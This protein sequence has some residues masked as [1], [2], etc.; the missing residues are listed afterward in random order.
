MIQKISVCYT[1]FKKIFKIE[2]FAFMIQIKFQILK[3]KKTRYDHDT[4]KI[5]ISTEIVKKN[6]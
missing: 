4:D 2:V 6:K 3:Q 1:K 5:V